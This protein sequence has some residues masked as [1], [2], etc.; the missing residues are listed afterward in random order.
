MKERALGLV[1]IFQMC[2]FIE[3]ELGRARERKS[4]QA[5]TCSEARKVGHERGNEPHASAE[6]SDGGIEGWLG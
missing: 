4:G 3:R 1:R 6:S 2:H 5:R